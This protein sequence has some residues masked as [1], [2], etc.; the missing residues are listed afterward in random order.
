MP[1]SARSLLRVLG[2]LF[3][4]AIIVVLCFMRWGDDLLIADQP[5]PRHV[6]AAIV[7]QGSIAAE[8]ARIAGA[9][10]LLQQGVADR[11]LL[12]VP[13]ESYWGQSIPPV[14]RA[15]LERTY[16][17]DL[18]ARVDFCETGAEVNSTLQEARAMSP[19]IREHHWQSIVIV[20]SNYHTRRARMIWRKITGPNPDVHMG[21][22]GVPDPEFQLPWWRHRQSAK[23]WLMESLKLVWAA[24]GG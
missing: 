11:A 13:K 5:P 9:I 3:P 23:I 14:A 6:D 12:S 24:F 17:S 20:T 4:A 16:G 2:W 10:T 7:L 19:C 21:I 22:E 18:A 8:K 15:F 1:P